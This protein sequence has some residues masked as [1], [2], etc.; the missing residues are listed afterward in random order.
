MKYFANFRFHAFLWGLMMI[1]FVFAPDVFT[2]TFVKYGKP[3]QTN[4]NIPAESDRIHFVIE[5]LTPY[6]KD[7]EYLYQLIGWSFM[8]P[9]AGTSSE[10]FVPEIALVADERKYFFSATT[11]SRQPKIPSKFAEIDLDFENLGLTILI[12]EDVI[13]PGKYR[14]GVIYRNPSDGSAFYRDKP[15]YYLV[16]TPNTLRLEE[17]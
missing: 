2:L 5:D 13:K 9:E 12:A 8:L 3:L 7:G 14:V 15:V 16:K 17:E 6:V 10:R 4:T 1:Y 11:G